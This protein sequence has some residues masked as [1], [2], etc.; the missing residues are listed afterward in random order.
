MTRPGPTPRK[1]RYEKPVI[2]FLEPRDV[3]EV[4]SGSLS[5]DPDASERVLRAL[6]NGPAI[7]QFRST[8]KYETGTLAP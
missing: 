1:Y 3:C 4:L 8:Q 2:Q 7:S 5:T 6:R